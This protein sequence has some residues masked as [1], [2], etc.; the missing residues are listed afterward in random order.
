MAGQK[1]SSHNIFWHFEIQIGM[2]SQFLKLTF[3]FRNTKTL[4]LMLLNH[5]NQIIG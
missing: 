1:P 3:K 5:H 2:K 4:S